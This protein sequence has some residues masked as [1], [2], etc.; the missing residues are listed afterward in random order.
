MEYHVVHAKRRPNQEEVEGWYV[1]AF[2]NGK[3]GE[4]VSHLYATWPQA[5]AQADRL[6]NALQRP[7]DQ[8]TPTRNS[9]NDGD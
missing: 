5:K 7:F 8:G 9:L 6:N 2:S 3:L 1:Q 4:I